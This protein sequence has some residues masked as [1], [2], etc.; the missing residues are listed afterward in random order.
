MPTPAVSTAPIITRDKA[1]VALSAA[2]EIDSAK[3][4]WVGVVANCN[5]GMGKGFRLVHRLVRALRP[6]GLS[7]TDAVTPEERALLVG[8]SAGDPR[9][10][11]LVAVGGDG[12]VADLLNKRPTVPLTVFPAGTENL[13][14]RHFGLGRDPKVLAKT[15]AGAKP[16]RVDVGLAWVADSCSWPDSASMVTSSPGTINDVYRAFG[17]GASDPPNRLRLASLTIEFFISVPAHHRTDR[18]SRCRGNVDRFDSFRIQCPPV[19]RWGFLSYP[20]QRT[21]MVGST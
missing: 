7:A 1:R 21:T 16:I 18:R 6:A 9:C 12:T 8:R 19:M 20:R 13:V 5:S 3:S 4:D 2:D 17:L 10:R 15:I 14:A 11:C